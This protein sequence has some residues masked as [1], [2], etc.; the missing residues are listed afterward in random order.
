M[1]EPD[2]GV[3]SANSFI[4]SDY[5]SSSSILTKGFFSTC[6]NGT[7]I[8]FSLLSKSTLEPVTSSPLVNGVDSSPFAINVTTD[9]TA[10]SAEEYVLAADFESIW[11]SLMFP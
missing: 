1:F 6:S 11:N 3:V 10:G 7:E 2:S 4:A 5:D 8:T 9:G